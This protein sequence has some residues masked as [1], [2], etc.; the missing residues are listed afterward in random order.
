MLGDL[1]DKFISIIKWVLDLRLWFW[2]RKLYV[3][4]GVWLCVQVLLDLPSYVTD[5]DML[6]ILIG[7]EVLKYF[8]KHD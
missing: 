5:R 7:I 2:V 8:G 4:L 6:K 1:I 3:P